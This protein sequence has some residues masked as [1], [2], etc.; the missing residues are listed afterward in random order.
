LLEAP[1]AGLDAGYTAAAEELR[2]R[3]FAVVVAHPE[4]SLVSLAAGWRVL[5]RE[6]G[7]GSRV[8]LNAWSTAGV[9]G[10]QVRNHALRLLR[11]APD[12]AVAS[13]AHGP[14]RM[15]SL[16]LALTALRELGERR[17]QRLVRATPRALLE[18][19]LP[20]PAVLAA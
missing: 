8:Q 14:E 1:F 9:Y 12:A 11:L 3:G 10:E 19:G 18:H 20:A 4:R 17:P 2:A 5:Q 15:P 7:A 16:Q 6:L 13:D